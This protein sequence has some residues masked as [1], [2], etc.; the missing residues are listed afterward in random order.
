MDFASIQCTLRRPACLFCPLRDVCKAAGVA[1]VRYELAERGARR[2][3]ERRGD[4][5]ATASDGGGPAGGGRPG[6][7]YLGSTRYL[8]GRI[9]DAARHLP[10]GGVLALADVEAVVAAHSAGGGHDVAGLVAGLVRDGLLAQV[11]AG[12]RLP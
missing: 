6:A 10:G 5:A 12:Y 4:Y 1:D 7:A 9:V 3:A 8:R 2:A 11:E